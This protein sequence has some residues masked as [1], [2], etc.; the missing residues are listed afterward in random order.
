MDKAVH[1]YNNERPHNNINK[2]SPVDF[3][4][5]WLTKQLPNNPVLTIFDNEVLT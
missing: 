5:K 4:N 1:H 3:E 2:L